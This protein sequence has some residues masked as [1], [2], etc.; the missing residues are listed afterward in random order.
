MIRIISIDRE[1]LLSLPYQFPSSGGGN[2]F[3]EFPVFRAAAEGLPEE[4][5]GLLLTSDLQGTEPEKFTDAPARLIGKTLAEEIYMLSGSAGIP[6]ADRIGVILAGDL[7]SS[8]GKRG[9]N[10]DVR[11]VWQTFNNH[12][13]WVAGVAGNH[14]QF[15]NGITDLEEFRQTQGIHYLDGESV[16][17][18]SLQVGGVGGIIGNPRRPF[19]RELN[20]YLALVSQVGQQVPAVM[21]LHESPSVREQS[22]LGNDDLRRCLDC[23]PP[24]LTVCGHCRWPFPA[25]WELESGGQVCNVDGRAVLLTNNTD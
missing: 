24:L 2:E 17:I 1:P 13:G 5:E 20:D 10:G 19:R 6:T 9:G 18:S 21:V 12:F 4:L 15:G 8:P 25:L 23:L 22:W 11:D 14:D 7:H 16:A 3:G